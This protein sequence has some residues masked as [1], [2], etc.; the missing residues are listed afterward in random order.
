MGDE[1]ETFVPAAWQEALQKYTTAT[2]RPNIYVNVSNNTNGFRIP[3]ARRDDFMN[4]NDVPQT[5]SWA[6]RKMIAIQDIMRT[7]NCS[8]DRA[9]L[10]WNKLWEVCDDEAILS[11]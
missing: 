1:T 9:E 5:A 3:E 7:F 10:Q 6:A 11:I 2:S 8:L 4:T